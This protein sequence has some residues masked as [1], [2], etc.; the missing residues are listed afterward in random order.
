MNGI[1]AVLGGAVLPEVMLTFHLTPSIA[2][3]FIAIPAV[4]VILA[5]MTG[6]MFARALDITRTLTFSVLGL[7]LSLLLIA[8]APAI[9]ILLLGALFFGV[10]NGLIETSGNALIVEI[11]PR[12][13]ARELNLIH[14]FFGIGAFVSPM[15][16]AFLF[17]KGVPWRVG[18]LIPASLILF[19]FGILLRQPSLKVSAVGVVEE[20]SL[21]Q[22]FRNQLVF[23]AWVGAFLLLA[24]EQG[25]T[26]WVTT[27]MRQEEILLPHVASVGLAIFW[28]S[29]LA[30]RIVNTRLPPGI[31]PKKIII[32]QVIGT[33]LSLL[34]VLVTRHPLF[35]LI[36]LGLVGL[37]MAGIYPALLVYASGQN[38]SFISVISGIFVTGVG[39]GK[40]AG[41]MIIGLVAETFD[42][43]YVMY[44]TVI[45]ILGVGLVFLIP[46]RKPSSPAHI[47]D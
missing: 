13:A 33:A 38:T 18:Y 42:L 9:P 26:G 12:Q 27:Y 16:I 5:G 32:A 14:F 28:L 3:L 8:V 47:S 41:P 45:L 17:S 46:L 4:G 24:T 1:A 23:Q 43:S 22:W 29:M 31:S 10:V 25:V 39:L 44:L 6:G 15:L 30:G 36:G 20:I 21:W 37:F 2:G 11:Y 7:G 35:G 34:V 19:L 40:L